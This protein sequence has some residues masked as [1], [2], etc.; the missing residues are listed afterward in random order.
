MA[1]YFFL[2]ASDLFL[3]ALLEQVIEL[4]VEAVL[5]VER[6][7]GRAPFVEDLHRR[8]VV[9]RIQQLVL[10][11]VLAESLTCVLCSPCR[12][13]ISGVPV[14]AR[15]VALGNASN[16]LSPRSEPCVRCASSIISRMRSESFTTPNVLP[17][18]MAR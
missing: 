14:K 12:S 17:A 3:A 16:R 6:S 9:H 10:V 4:R 8:A 11:D 1:P 13:V 2:M 5:V 15:R 7:V 18:G